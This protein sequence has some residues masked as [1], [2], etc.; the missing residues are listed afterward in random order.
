MKKVNSNSNKTLQ[1]L[2]GKSGYN[3]LQ[4]CQVCGIS[5]S[6]FHKYVTGK[7][8]P[9]TEKLISMSKTLKISLKQMCQLLGKDVT[10]VPNDE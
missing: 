3:I 4:F 7:V 9:T 1:D 5:E 2:I 8:D 10:G 6:S